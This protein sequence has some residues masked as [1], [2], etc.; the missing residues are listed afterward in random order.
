MY[1]ALEGIKGSGKT[2]VFEG[3]YAELKRQGFAPHCLRP[4]AARPAS[5]L[6][7]LHVV[8]GR[9]WPDRLVEQLY[10]SRSNCAARHL[11]RRG[12]VLGERSVFTSYVTRWDAADPEASMARVDAL[13]HCIQLPQHVLYLNVPVEVAIQRIGSRPSRGYGNG[14]QAASRLRDT[15]ALYRHLAGM[16]ERYGLAPVQWHWVDATK[17]LQTVVCEAARIVVALQPR[18]VHAAPEY[19]IPAHPKTIGDYA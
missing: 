15:D 14:D 19:E 5:I 16:G 13:E 9:Y 12:L 3:V 17:P 10:A 8:S 2:A 11:P 7:A 6:D 1:F 4:V 18:P